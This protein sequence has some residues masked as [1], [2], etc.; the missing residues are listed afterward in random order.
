MTITVKVQKYIFKFD[1]S[2][3][4]HIG[5]TQSTR[6]PNLGAMQ[7]QG[8]IDVHLLI[9]YCHF[10]AILALPKVPGSL[11]Q[12]PYKQRAYLLHLRAWTSDPWAINFPMLAESFMKI[13]TMHLIFSQLCGSREEYFCILGPIYDPR[14]GKVENSSFHID[15]LN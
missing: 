5:T 12:E 13:T 15:A 3:C 2:L 9:I 7:A 1:L 4:C 8:Y 14:G 10:V 6:I 11:T